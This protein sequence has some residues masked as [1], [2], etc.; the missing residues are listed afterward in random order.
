MDR[1]QNPGVAALSG[2]QEAASAPDP[3][4]AGQ[5][6][7]ATGPDAPSPDDICRPLLFGSTE[8]HL[9]RSLFRR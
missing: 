6:D 5:G 2:Q 3:A 1:L 4:I 7:R 9:R 8:P